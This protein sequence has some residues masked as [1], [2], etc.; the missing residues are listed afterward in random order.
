MARWAK[1]PTVSTAVI[2]TPA[3]KAPVLMASLA[4][5]LK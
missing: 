2:I 5:S 3:R 1:A 4:P